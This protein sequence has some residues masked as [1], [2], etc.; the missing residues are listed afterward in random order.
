MASAALPASMPASPHNG[1]SGARRRNTAAMRASPAGPIGG[2]GREHAADADI[3]DEL[4]GRRLGLHDR[5]HGKPDD[6]VFPQQ[7]PGVDGRHV[8]LSHMRAGGT[9][10]S[11]I[12]R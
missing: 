11:M 5:L 10:G 7:P 1:R 12:I 4:D 3:V 6:G 8:V 2:R 9:G